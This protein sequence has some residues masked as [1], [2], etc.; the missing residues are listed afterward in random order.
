MEY[1]IHI[2][3]VFRGIKQLKE[4]DGN[5]IEKKNSTEE[6]V[7]NVKVDENLLYKR[8]GFSQSSFTKDLHKVIS[9][10]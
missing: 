3:L 10:K 8:E 4:F 1:N 6:R 7:E 5:G 2:K 9:Q